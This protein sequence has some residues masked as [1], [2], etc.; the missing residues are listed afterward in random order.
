LV[1]DGPH[2]ATILLDAGARDLDD[3]ALDPTRTGLV[4]AIVTLAFTVEATLGFGATV[5]AVALGSLVVPIDALLPA[6]VP[7]NVVLSAGLVARGAKHVQGRVIAREILPAMALG[8]PVGLFAFARLPRAGLQLGFA[9]FV[10]ALSSLELARALRRRGESPPLAPPIARALLF[11]GG[12]VHGAFATGGPPVVYVCGRVLPDK[13]AFRATLSVVWLVLNAA[14]L[15][16][17]GATA[18]LGVTTA[19]QSLVLVP[20]LA[21]GALVGERLHGHVPERAFRVGV[22]AMLVVVAVIL[23]VRALGG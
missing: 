4:L 5:V 17:Y 10:L 19:K 11:V 13:R 1:A 14:L 9:I 2:G 18:R 6:F 8:F 21:V 23:A 3:F 7:V 16:V 12:V 20:G 15:V 22:F